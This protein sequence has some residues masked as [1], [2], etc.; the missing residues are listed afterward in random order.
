MEKLV[1]SFNIYEDK[2][3]IKL[4]RTTAEEHY[5]EG[6]LRK[7]G[8]EALSLGSILSMISTSQNS[9]QAQPIAT[10]E[11]EYDRG[12]IQAVRR[13]QRFW[14]HVCPKVREE[15]NL[16]KTPQGRLTVQLKNIC[17]QYSTTGE[18]HYL[19]TSEGVKLHE[20]HRTQSVAVNEIQQRAV[21]LACTLS[22]DQFETV[23]EVI[24]RIRDTEQEMDSVGANISADRL[25]ELA[26]RDEDDVRIVFHRVSN[27]LQKVERD[28]RET[29]H[30][31][32]TVQ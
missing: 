3:A 30:L 4:V 8:V 25:R 11:E 32:E 13:I 24:D 19:L 7:L 20:R 1:K 21:D 16:M 5:F 22:H 6:T 14:R 23:N 31:L 28:V 2:D 12:H 10:S 9:A 26:Q 29:T 15:R 18:T 17:K 27:A